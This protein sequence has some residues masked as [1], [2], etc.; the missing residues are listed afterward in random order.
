[1]MYSATFFS[2][3]QNMRVLILYLYY[4]N[5]EQR[6]LRRAC[7]IMQTQYADVDEGS[8]LAI[9]HTVIKPNL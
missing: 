2:D 5:Y 8:G 1:M 9:T 6:R 4:D 3:M 7:R